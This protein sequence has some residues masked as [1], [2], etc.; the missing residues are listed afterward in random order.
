MTHQI[1]H[2]RKNKKGKVF[3]A[4]RL[5]TPRPIQPKGWK[6]KVGDTIKFLGSGE[7][8]LVTGISQGKN[9]QYITR[10]MGNDGYRHTFSKKGTEMH[11]VLAGGKIKKNLLGGYKI[12]IP[13]F[14]QLQKRAHVSGLNLTH[15]PKNEIKAGLPPFVLEGEFWLSGY[16]DKSP[17]QNTLHIEDLREVFREIRTNEHE[18]QKVEGRTNNIEGGAI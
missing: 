2:F 17:L 14:E 6:Y 13:S 8:N 9:P 11:T 1:R 18:K 16:I 3:Y 4:G 5:R 12:E 7:H 15:T 10:D